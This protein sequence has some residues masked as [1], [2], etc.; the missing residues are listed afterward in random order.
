MVEVITASDV[1]EFE[2][3]PA[4]QVVV[5]QDSDKNE[6]PTDASPSAR[7]NS[8]ATMIAQIADTSSQLSISDESVSVPISEGNGLEVTEQTTP[9]QAANVQTPPQELVITLGETS[10]GP[11]DWKP[12]VKGSPHL[13]IIGIPGQGKSV[14]TSHIL[15]EMARQQVPALVLD[16]HGQFGDAQGSY[17]CAS[18]VQ[19]LDA[20][21]G[22]PFSPFEVIEQNGKTDWKQN[23]TA[24][25]DIFAYVVGLGGIQKDLLQNAI[26]DA[27]K[28]HGYA[29]DD[30]SERVIPTTEEVLKN[31]EQREQKQKVR[32]V[33]ARCRPLLEMDLFKPIAGDSSLLAQIRQGLVIDLHD[34]MSE[35]LQLAAGAFVLRKLYR[36]MFRWG[37]ASGIRLAIVLDEAH[38]LA[39]D[40]TLPKLMKEGRKYGIAVVVASQGLSDFHPGVLGN[41]GTKVIFRTNYPES[42]KLARYVQPRNFQEAA[43]QI[44][45]L[46][47]G[48]AFV[49]T[50]EMQQGV[51]VHMR[52]SEL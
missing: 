47:V 27:Y 26:Q 25:A 14:T 15:I 4:T 20:S 22:L 16:F 1:G 24:L 38:R 23:S 28:T 35:T 17:A 31:I 2:A 33:A 39:K 30:V 12:S 8:S 13:F 43:A 40:V 49:Q 10:R 34:L 41:A 44:E 36:D 18:Q 48:N 46:T 52:S 50:P 32:N 29:T 6:T 3:S 21:D 42:G 5:S 9:T 37:T 11:V 7:S 19:R 45:Q 51:V